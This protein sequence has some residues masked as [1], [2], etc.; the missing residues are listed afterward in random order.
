M[1][2]GYEWVSALDSRT[3]QICQSLDGRRFKIGEGPTTPAHINCRST[4]T[5]VLSEAFSFLD[6]GATRASKGD[7]GGKQVNANETYYSW[8]KKQDRD[9]Q[10]KAIGP[11]RTKLLNN[12]GLNADEFARLSLNRNFQPMTLDEMYKSQ[13]EVFKNAG[14]KP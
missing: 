12:G 13:P 8:L 6:K 7:S 11:T 5:P 4:T 9:F 3:S 2:K 10:N 1:V 14:I